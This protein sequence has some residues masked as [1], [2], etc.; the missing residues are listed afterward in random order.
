L[1]AALL[2]AGDAPFLILLL[3]ADVLLVAGLWG[4]IRNIL[5]RARE[6]R[7]RM[8]ALLAMGALVVLLLVTGLAAEPLAEALALEPVAS[9]NVS[10]WG[11]GLIYVSPWLVGGWLAR[12]SSKLERYFD[13]VNRTVDLGWLFR[14]VGWVGRH[15]AGGV[16]WLGQVGEGDGWWGWALVVLALGAIFLAVR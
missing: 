6:R 3:L 15:L 5:L 10:I 11:L 14:R 8:T 13:Y 1:Y 12:A 7:P 16:H 9:A 2:K 4:A